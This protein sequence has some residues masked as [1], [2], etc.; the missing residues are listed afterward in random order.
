MKRGGEGSTEHKTALYQKCT[1]MYKKNPS[2]YKK[3]PKCTAPP[4][5]PKQRPP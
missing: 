1:E 4:F 3:P 2:P 5:V